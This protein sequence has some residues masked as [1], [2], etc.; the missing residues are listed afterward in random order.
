M[1]GGV[2]YLALLSFE[3]DSTVRRAD[4]YASRCLSDSPLSWRRVGT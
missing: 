1:A 3:G 4:E 2:I